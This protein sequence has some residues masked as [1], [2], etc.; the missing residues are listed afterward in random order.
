MA[1]T[2]FARPKAP[3]APSPAKA[4]APTAAKSVVIT[5]AMIAKRAHEIWEKHGRPHGHAESHWL[6]AERELR[7]AQQPTK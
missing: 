4:T 6:Q 5:D 7:A 3:A 2:I 1:K